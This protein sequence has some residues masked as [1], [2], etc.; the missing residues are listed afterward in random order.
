MASSFVLQSIFPSICVGPAGPGWGYEAG[1]SMDYFS[2][3]KTSTNVPFL[4]YASYTCFY[5]YFHLF[6]LV[7]MMTSATAM[8]C[9]FVD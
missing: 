7:M 8:Y 1:N 2:L 4:L 9:K 5:Q 6:S 3:I